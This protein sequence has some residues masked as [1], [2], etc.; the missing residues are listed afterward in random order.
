[1]ALPQILKNIYNN[2]DSSLRE[3]Q[4]NIDFSELFIGISLRTLVYIFREKVLN[5]LFQTNE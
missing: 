2:L 3:T 1:M 4:I 5:F